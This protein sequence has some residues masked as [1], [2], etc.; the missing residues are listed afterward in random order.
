LK[1]ASILKKLYRINDDY[2]FNAFSDQMEIKLPPGEHQVIPYSI[3]P[4]V[5]LDLFEKI[6]I[7]VGKIQ[8]GSGYQWVG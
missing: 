1:F 2:S 3:K 7:R 8:S 4:S 5:S 6:D